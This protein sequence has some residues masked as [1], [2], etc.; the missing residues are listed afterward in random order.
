MSDS[1]QLVREL[2]EMQKQLSIQ[3]L[4]NTNIIAAILC[5]LPE[6]DAQQVKKILEV[7]AASGEFHGLTLDACQLANK[8][9]CAAIDSDSLPD[10]NK[11]L[12]LVRGG[13]ID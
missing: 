2:F 6:H 13:K 8:L 12:R 1:E 11:M 10:P 4:A 3:M 7:Q 9:V 5:S